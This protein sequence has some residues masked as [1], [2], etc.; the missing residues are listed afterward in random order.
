MASYDLTRVV[1]S[2][3]QIDSVIKTG[4]LRAAMPD[5]YTYAH[6]PRDR[7]TA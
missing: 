4:Q 3:L 1:D 2:A 5:V 6:T 7:T